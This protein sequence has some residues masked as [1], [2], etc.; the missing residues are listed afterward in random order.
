MWS[1]DEAS[2]MCEKVQKS[3][4]RCKVPAIEEEWRGSR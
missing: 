2:E 3:G 1:L 4:L